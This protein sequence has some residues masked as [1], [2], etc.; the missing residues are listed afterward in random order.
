[1]PRRVSTDDLKVDDVARHAHL[2]VDGMYRRVWHKEPYW[3]ERHNGK[4]K[5]EVGHGD[6]INGWWTDEYWWVLDD[7]EKE[8]LT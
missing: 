5:W 8:Q 1:M 7:D 2:S 3:D 4:M 6:E